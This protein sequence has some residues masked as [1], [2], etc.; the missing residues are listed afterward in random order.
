MKQGNQDIAKKSIAD[1]INNLPHSLN[2]KISVCKKHVKK[3]LDIK[4][5]KDKISVEGPHVKITKHRYCF[6][7]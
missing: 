6:T 4:F 1:D 3:F 7:C 5:G 2:N